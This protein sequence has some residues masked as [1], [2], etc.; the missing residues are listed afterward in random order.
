MHVQHSYNSSINGRNLLTYA[1]TLSATGPEQKS[2][3]N[4]NQT[5][6]FQPLGRISITHDSLPYQCRRGLHFRCWNSYTEVLPCDTH[7]CSRSRYEIIK[8]EKETLD[9]HIELATLAKRSIEPC[10][11]HKSASSFG[12]IDILIPWI[13]YTSPF[14]NT[15]RDCFRSDRTGGYICIRQLITSL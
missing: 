15:N 8:A 10:G 13:N 12:R 14:L 5:H 4:E 7:P 2:C 6:D 11:A 9:G 3:L 1:L